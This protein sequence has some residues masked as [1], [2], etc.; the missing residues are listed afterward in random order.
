MC[1]KLSNFTHE[2]KCAAARGEGVL[3]AVVKDFFVLTSEALKAEGA[4]VSGEVR[5]ASALRLNIAFQFETFMA[6]GMY[7]TS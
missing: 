4:L 2:A 1:V 7:G 6:R 5:L 3:I